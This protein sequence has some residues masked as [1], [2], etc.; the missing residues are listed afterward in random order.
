MRPVGGVAGTR[1]VIMTAGSMSLAVVA[2]VRRGL[3]CGGSVAAVCLLLA[4][5]AGPAAD[6]GAYRHA[7]LNTAM[8]MVSSLAA[9]QL[10][11][12]DDL[13]GR[14]LLAFTDESVTNAENDADSVN[15]TFGSRQP[16]GPGSQALSQKMDQALSQGTSA[17]SSLRIAIR[18]GSRQQ[19]IKALAGVRKALRLFRGLQQSLQ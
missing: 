8:A 10:A 15:S 6:Y 14:N 18:Q 19:M 7:A 16:V 9:A 1:E 17:L 11:V 3:A 2:R 12:Q 4:G 5:C 13:R